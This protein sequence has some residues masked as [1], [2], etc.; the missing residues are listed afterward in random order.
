MGPECSLS[1]GGTKPTYQGQ[2][3]HGVQGEGASQHMITATSPIP[4]PPPP[5][6]GHARLALSGGPICGKCTMQVAY[7]YDADVG[8]YYYGQGHPMKPHR[9][10]MAHS[11]IL[12]YGLYSQ[13]EVSKNMGVTKSQVRLRRGSRSLDAAA[14][15]YQPFLAALPNMLRYSEA[16]AAMSNESLVCRHT[17]RCRRPRRP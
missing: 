17:R 16:T 14:A 15:V 3:G 13:M 10:K 1:R 11:L 5:P 7:F 2:G 8:K 9:V 6:P 12:H 4:H